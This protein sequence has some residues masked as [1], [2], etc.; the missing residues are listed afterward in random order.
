MKTKASF[1]H[2]CQLP[3]I[4]GKVSLWGPPRMARTNIPGSLVPAFLG[5]PTCV[6]LAWTVIY[7]ENVCCFF[8]YIHHSYDSTF[9]SQRTTDFSPM[10]T[11]ETFSHV[12]NMISC[13]ANQVYM[14]TSSYSHGITYKN[15]HI[16]VIIILIVHQKSSSSSPSSCSCSFTMCIYIYNYTSWH[17]MLYTMLILLMILISS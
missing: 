3:Q 2:T 16:L 10:L 6:S 7:Y 5:C 11:N 15:H 9:Q 4:Y 12:I 17:V 1:Q 14:T 8:S 13:S